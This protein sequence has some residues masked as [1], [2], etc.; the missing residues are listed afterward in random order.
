MTIVIFLAE[1]SAEDARQQEIALRELEGLELRVVTYPH[2]DALDEAERLQPDMVIL[3]HERPGVTGFALAARFRKSAVLRAVP[4]LITTSDA[5]RDQ[6]D[7]HRASP[8]RADF[9]LT[10]PWSL[11]ELEET[12]RMLAARARDK[13]ALMDA[14]GG[15]PV[16]PPRL[17][18]RASASPRRG[19]SEG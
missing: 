19:R 11:A 7:R 17:P 3:R 15:G 2:P 9:Y 14:A 13:A 1:P 6:I 18:S 5:T 10:L 4:M 8:G 16:D 12:I